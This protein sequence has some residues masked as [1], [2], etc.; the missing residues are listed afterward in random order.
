MNQQQTILDFLASIWPESASATRIF[1]KAGTKGRAA[2]RAIQD[3][4]NA[5]RIE[6][7]PHA[8]FSGYRLTYEEAVKQ[9]VDMTP[10]VK[11]RTDHVYSRPSYKPPS[12]APARSDAN[13]FI[14]V[15]SRR[16]DEYVPQMTPIHMGS[17]IPGGMA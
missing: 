7:K 12:M 15:Y 16:G 4:N 17:Q 3:L 6:V 10:T 2:E 5:G 11:S 9:G 8:Y 13:D 1:A 14:K